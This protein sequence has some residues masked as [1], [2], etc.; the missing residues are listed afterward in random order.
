MP[1]ESESDRSLGPR[2]PVPKPIGHQMNANGDALVDALFPS[3]PHLQM[4]TGVGAGFDGEDEGPPVLDVHLPFCDR[5][6]FCR[7]PLGLKYLN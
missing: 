5:R 4:L 1:P 3:P 6:P 7:C 2:I